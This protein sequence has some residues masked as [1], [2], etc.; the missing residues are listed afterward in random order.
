[1][2]Y[3]LQENVFGVT[4]KK[5]LH[6]LCVRKFAGRSR[7]K[8]FRASLGKVRQ[9]SF[10]PPRIYL[11]LH[12]WTRYISSAHVF[13]NDQQFIPPNTPSKDMLKLKIN[14]FFKKITEN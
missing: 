12:P 2:A 7:T 11:L 13:I 3:D 10:T 9:K 1:M 6:D 4:S 8:T 14:Q 5:S